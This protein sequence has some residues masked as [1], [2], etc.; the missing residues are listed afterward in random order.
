M[1]DFIERSKDSVGN[2]LDLLSFILV[3]PELVRYAWPAM[4]RFLAAIASSIILL[5]LFSGTI[6]GFI[7]ILFVGSDDYHINILLKV[8]L[9]ISLF[10]GMLLFVVLF[11][12]VFAASVQSSSFHRL[13]VKRASTRHLL[14]L[15]IILFFF[16]DL[17]S[18][19][20]R[21]RLI[22]VS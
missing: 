4:G 7:L 13:I 17:S 12:W 19:R 21:R 22:F 1:W 11:G 14:V 5:L 18:F 20:L 10:G 16:A 9:S 8:V 3:T 6:A 2:A 15:G